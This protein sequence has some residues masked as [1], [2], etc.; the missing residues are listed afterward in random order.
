M[1]QSASHKLLQYIIA[2]KRSTPVAAIYGAAIVP[3]CGQ[4]SPCP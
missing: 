4:G 2:M 1:V 3:G